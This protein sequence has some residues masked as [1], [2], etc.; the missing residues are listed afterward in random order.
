MALLPLNT[1]TGGGLRPVYD[2]E[3]A[4]TENV[5]LA[6]AKYF[7]R[8]T[9]LGQVLGTGTAVAE[10]QTMTGTG[11]LTGG[12]YRLSFDGYVTAAIA[13]D[14]SV[15]T[16]ELAL[17]ALANVGTDG[18][19]VGGGAFPGTPVTFTFANAL[20]GLAQPLIQVISSITGGGTVAIART[21]AGK[22]AKGYW[23]AYDDAAAGDFAGL[24]VARRL[25][26]YDCRTDSNG[27][28]W[29]GQTAG[30]SDNNRFDR[31]ASTFFA[32]TFRTGDGT[33]LLRPGLD[34]AA[35]ADLGKLI[36]GSTATLTADTTILRIG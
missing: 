26:Q 24:A 6:A 7:P 30:V 28:V 25:L 23:D 20:A 35:V 16:I 21:T 19:L 12:S 9:V 17:E 29:P 1:Y 8:G 15:A 13:Y 34:A 27:R 22:P 32:G 11:T 33:S 31:Y 14:A 18:I 10:V 5:A 2:S 36:A 3:G 4:F